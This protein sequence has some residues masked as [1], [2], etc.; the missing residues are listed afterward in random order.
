MHLTDVQL[1]EYLD[2][3]IL[4][5]EQIETHVSTCADCAARLAALQALFSEI[6]SLPELALSQ[7]IA[8]RFRL[9]KASSL[10]AELPRSLTLTVIL[11]AAAAIIA[12]ITASPF[13]MRFVSPYVSIL[14]SPSLADI[15]LQGQA[16][17]TTWLDML[18]QFQLP[19][20]PQIPAVELSGLF[21]MLTVAGVS[22]LWLVGNGLLLRNQNK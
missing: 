22:I 11:Q 14:P 1:N 3:E 18:S 21:L 5:R 16:Q 20:L 2:N 10:P 19:T 6:E 4:D 15:I 9:R 7:D 12:M 8:S 13:V 17:W